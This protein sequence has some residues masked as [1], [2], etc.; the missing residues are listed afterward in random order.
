MDSPASKSPD[1]D[2]ELVWSLCSLKLVTPIGTTGHELSLSAC[3]VVHGVL[4]GVCFVFFLY[5][6]NDCV[7]FSILRM[8][9]LECFGMVIVF[10]M[11]MMVIMKAKPEGDSLILLKAYLSILGD[12]EV[13]LLAAPKRVCS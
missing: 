7:F 9:V 3:G 11:D 1:H 4:A 10:G 8:I 2:V 13:V 5:T 6:K 12:L